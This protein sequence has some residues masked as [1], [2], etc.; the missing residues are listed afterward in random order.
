[1]GKLKFFGL[2][3]AAGMFAACSDNLENAGNENDGPK[4]GEGYVKVAINLPSVSSSRAFN[5]SGSLDDGTSDEYAVNDAI[6]VFFK[7]TSSAG[8]GTPEATAQFAK[9]YNVSLN[10]AGEGDDNH[11]T[12]RHTVIREAPLPADGE[13]VYALAILN[14]NGVFTVDEA[15]GVL[16]KNGNNVF[17]STKTLSALQTAIETTAAKCTTTGFMM[18]SAPLATTNTPTNITDL[19]KVQTLVPVT[20]YENQTLAENGDVA[21]IY[22][23]RVVAKVTLTGFTY[24]D[25]KYTKTVTADS[26]DPF[27]G[28]KVEFEGWTLNYTNKTFKPVRD[29]DAITTWLGSSYGTV[30]RFLGTT[31][32]DNK[33]LY[34]IYWAE[35]GNYDVSYGGTEGS[36]AKEAFNVFTKP[37]DITTWNTN[38]ADNKTDLDED[39]ALYC[40]EN[41]MDYDKQAT[42]QTTS[43]ILKTKYIADPDATGTGAQ[44]FF[45]YGTQQVTYTQTQFL[46]NVGTALSLSDGTTAFLKDEATGGTYT[47]I[48]NGETAGSGKY[49]NKKDVKNLIK[50]SS[51]DLNDTQAQTLI[52]KLGEIK[53]YKDGDSYYN[54]V[55]IRHFYDDETPWDAGETYGTKHLGRYGVVRNNWYEI[56]VNSISGPGEPTIDDDTENPN[57]DDEEEGYIK[58]QINVLSWARRSQ[59]VD[60]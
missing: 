44:N 6:L 8:D 58:C 32:V 12:N 13:K 55:L 59:S 46:T 28:D 43:L 47:Y 34:R 5:E 7:T 4:T 49:L 15:N 16:K 57:P 20:V 14:A 50:L 23:E 36:D 9:A 38:T 11:V 18:L 22:V 53:F 39:Y 29:V 35:D 56:D 3:L 51:G 40:L 52:Q 10:P 31:K 27:N 30:S 24:A 21:S 19:T 33:D 41:T 42:N 26:G 2:L 45:M 17:A 60:L 54:V 37:E 48:P 25:S 1:M